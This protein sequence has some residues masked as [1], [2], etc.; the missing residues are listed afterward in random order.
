MHL[1]PSFSPHPV[2]STSRSTSIMN[3]TSKLQRFKDSVFFVDIQ[4]LVFLNILPHPHPNFSLSSNPAT[5]A[6]SLKFYLNPIN[7]S[8]WFNKKKT[9]RKYAKHFRFVSISIFKETIFVFLASS[10]CCPTLASFT[11][12][13]LPKLSLVFKTVCH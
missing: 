1:N 2:T 12:L 11:T 9:S 3:E 10:R 5:S 4:I 7:Y 13:K 8:T 6:S